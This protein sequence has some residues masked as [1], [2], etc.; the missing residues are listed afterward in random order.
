MTYKRARQDSNLQPSDSKSED[1][2]PKT[3]TNQELTAPPAATGAPHGAHSPSEHASAE[4]VQDTGLAAIVQA[5]PNL[6]KCVRQAMVTITRIVC[7]RQDQT[8]KG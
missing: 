6:P 3:Y 5:W 4:S 8:T 1:Q 7:P 2:V